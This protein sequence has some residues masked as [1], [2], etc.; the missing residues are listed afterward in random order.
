[1][2]IRFVLYIL[3]VLLL[4]E[5]GLM[6]LPGVVALLYG[7][8]DLL[9]M[10]L[11]SSALT[12]A[13]GG[14]LWWLN[15]GCSRMTGKREG[16]IIVGFVWVLFAFF[17]SLPFVFSG[18]A[19]SMTDAFFEAISG[20]TTTGATII[21]DIEAL[22]RGLLFWRALMHFTGGIGILVLCI[23]VLPI[24]GIGSMTIYQA[25]TSTAAA[26]SGKFTPRIKTTAKQIFIIYLILTAACFLFYLPDMSIFDAV[27]HAFS[28]TATGGFST[29]TASMG[30][31]S[32]YTQYVTTVFM[33]LGSTPF[34]LFFYLWKGELKKV[35]QYD[36]FRFY[37]LI[38]FIAFAI[39]CVGLLFSGHGA[40]RSVR[41]SLFNVVS[42]FST[43][44]YAINDY[45]QWSPP[46]WFIIFLIA[47][48]GGCAGSTT[49]GLKVVRLLV[50]LRTIPVQFKKIMHPNAVIHVKI[51][52]QNISEDRIF[53]TFAFFMIFICVFIVGVLAFLL[54]G[55]N[56]TSAVGAS[57][58]CLS[59]SGPGLDMV[60]PATNFAHFSA[61]GKWACSFLMLLGR[62][63]LYPA[64]ILFSPAFWRV[65]N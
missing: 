53:R 49:G 20:F 11:C 34:V 28:T 44:G 26:G 42:I 19:P 57:V 31:Y 62:L 37:L 16:F 12:F 46:L 6:A 55:L 7:E 23:A 56:F 47:V 35:V 58:A 21:P 54:C 52:R 18:Y 33:L 8:H 38:I 2:N 29:K 64:L 27:C 24:F 36:E 41:E 3:G 51:N 48:V 59:N 39:I 15:R 60:G 61:A 65:G 14:T 50:L 40:E 17:G 9:L 5:G 10:L 43:T 32:V 30:A 4:L 25:E 13:V 1:M 45:M 22:P 63:E